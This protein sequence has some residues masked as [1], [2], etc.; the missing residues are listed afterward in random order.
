[1]AAEDPPPGV[2][3]GLDRAFH[4]GLVLKALDGLLEVAGGVVLLFVSPA[5]IQHLVRGLVANELTQDPHDFIAR[6]L[7]HSVAHLNRGTTLFGAAYL[8]SHGLVKL[9]LVVFVLRERLWAY[10]WLIAFLSAFIV[11]QVYRLAL[12][13]SIGLLGL[14]I[15][16]SALVWLTWREYQGRRSGA[17][18]T[19]RRRA[20]RS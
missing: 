12:H 11:Y 13:L 5:S 3:R 10:P 15:F 1:M 16:D 4:V 20:P 2:S 19:P 17:A 8:L 14:T 18:P 6:H 7:L 9:V